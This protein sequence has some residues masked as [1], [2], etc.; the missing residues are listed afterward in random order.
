MSDDVESVGNTYEGMCRELE[1][2]S[3]Q[4]TTAI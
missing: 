1:A 3:S 2:G 4:A